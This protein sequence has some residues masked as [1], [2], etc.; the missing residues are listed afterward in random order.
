MSSLRGKFNIPIPIGYGSPVR[1]ERTKE[2]LDLF[3]N[4]FKEIL[5]HA[6][7]DDNPTT[8]HVF[9]SDRCSKCKNELPSEFDVMCSSCHDNL[10]EADD[11]FMNNTDPAFYTV[12]DK[13]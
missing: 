10:N 1:I 6:R 12:C 13:L 4:I 2:N 11:N 9:Q 5:R 7:A 3:E 8:T